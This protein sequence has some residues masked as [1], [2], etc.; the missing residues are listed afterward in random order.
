MHI[1]HCVWTRTRNVFYGFIA[2][3]MLL[4]GGMAA[5]AHP[6]HAAGQRATAIPDAAAT[7]VTTY[8]Y[9]NS[10]TGQNTHESTLTTS[11]VNTSQFGKRV[12][13]P[14]D[15]QVYAQ[16]LFM[17]ELTINGN[18]HNVVIVATENDSV[19]AFDA[20]ATDP[21]TPPLWQTSFLTNG[22]T[23]PTVNDLLPGTGYLC[24]D[25]TPNIGITGT[26]VID[27]STGTL[28][29][30]AYTLENGQ[31]QYRLHALDL[32][33]G[34]DKPGSPTLIEASAPGNSSDSVDGI[35][36]FDPTHER[37]RSALLLANGQV[38]IAWGS[39][40]DVT[41]YHGWILSY[42]SQTL[43]QSGAF[44]DTPDGGLGGIWGSANALAADPTGNIYAITGNG[45]FDLNSGGRDA[46]DSFIKLDSGLHLLDS[47]TPFNQQCLEANDDDL[48]SGGPLLLPN[49]NEI[50]GAGKEGRIYVVDRG[51]MGQYTPADDPCGADLSR[52]DIDHVLQE[53]APQT[54][55]P[56]FSTPTY[57]NGAN[58]EYVFFGGV[59][60]TVKAYQLT[61]SQLAATPTSQ[62]AQQFSYPGGN[63]VVSSNG[64][65][66]G[67]G[68][69]WV[70]DSSATLHAYDATDLSQELYNSSTNADR[71]ALDS[72]VKFT[73][74]IVANGEV[75]VGTQTSLT[76]YGL[77]NG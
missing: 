60:D 44:N 15:G 56:L 39:F 19:Y 4:L 70:L 66:A 5:Y 13:F 40:C 12:S 54:I 27:P 55:G 3:C 18:V 69:L 33:T 75:F 62:T 43:R 57:W 31:L 17:P 21:A 45:T 32:T 61:G 73:A 74:P 46:G 38:Y 26:P 2:T 49:T 25:L 24:D 58:G 16:P 23:T 37:Q 1:S 64:A 48:G 53:S 28:F 71:D 11:N 22:A 68:V 36:T 30:V 9:D 63:S 7:A 10:V 76:I 72:Y 67:T 41:P 51:N 52:T 6:A 20:N 34:L 14:V 77:L 65:V 8:K 47:F 59:S 29:V 42:D 50:V 35:V